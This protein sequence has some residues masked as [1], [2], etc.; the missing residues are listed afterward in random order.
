MTVVRRADGMS[1]DQ[2]VRAS[3][4]QVLRTAYRIVGN[5]ADA[6]DIAQEVFVRLHRQGLGFP[7]EAGMTAW[8]YR[9]TVNLC[10]DRMRSPRD[11]M[12]S[13]W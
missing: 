5:W 7:N 9:V 8:L 6:E 1:F 4:A 11:D 13:T 10:L 12:R 3:E 2:A